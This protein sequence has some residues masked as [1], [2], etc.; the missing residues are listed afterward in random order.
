MTLTNNA[1]AAADK[2]SQTG[3]RRAGAAV[4]CLPFSPLP[5]W[6]YYVD[7]DDEAVGGL[8]GGLV[9]TGLKAVKWFTPPTTGGYATPSAARSCSSAYPYLY[10]WR[11]SYKP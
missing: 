6:H 2:D 1:A 5:L 11:L 8:V 9:C 4:S 3:G 10:S 7:D